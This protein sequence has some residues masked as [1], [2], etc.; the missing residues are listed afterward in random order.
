[1]RM[2][3]AHAASALL[4]DSRTILTVSPTEPE[5]AAIA[6]ALQAGLNA[7]T[8]AGA[9]V[10]VAVTCSE[11]ERSGVGAPQGAHA[12]VLLADLVRD[13]AGGRPEG[14]RCLRGAGALRRLHPRT[15]EVR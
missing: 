14:D 5:K 8:G 7:W 15:A 9:G 11:A 12:V 6:R 2:K 10:A 13:R 1:M 4:I 3:A